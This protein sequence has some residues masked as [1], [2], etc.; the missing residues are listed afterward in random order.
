MEKEVI[1]SILVTFQAALLAT[2]FGALFGIP[3]AY[4]LA[5]FDFPGR[6]WVEGA[7]NLPVVLPHSAA[8]IALLSVLGSRT[9]LG[10][11]AGAFGLSFVGT[12][13]AIAAAMAFVSLPFLVSAAVEA[14]RS[15]DPRLEL[16]ARTCGAGPGRAFT[17][18]TLPLALRGLIAGMVMMWARGISEFGAVLILA[19]HPMTAPVLIFERFTSFGLKYARPVA[20]LLLGLC[21]LVFVIAQWL[22]RGRRRA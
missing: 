22:D 18:I 14:F 1:A 19:Y 9:T 15:V 8:G 11:A 5:R 2:L 16:A 12:I 10:Q 6:R 7:I 4:L 20:V 13:P 3:L 21:L 17:R